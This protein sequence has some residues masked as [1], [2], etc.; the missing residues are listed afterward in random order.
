MW[1]TESDRP[2]ELRTA[3]R[4][5]VGSGMVERTSEP[6]SC[7]PACVDAPTGR[8][9]AKAIGGGDEMALECLLRGAELPWQGGLD[10]EPALIH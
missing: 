9:V 6:E 5:L 8:E 1:P 10:P 7:S 3:E 2:A 4:G